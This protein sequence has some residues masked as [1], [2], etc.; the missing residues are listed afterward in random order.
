MLLVQ[1]LPSPGLTSRLDSKPVPSSVFRAE[2]DILLC[3]LVTPSR[4]AQVELVLHS[5]GPLIFPSWLCQVFP[6][7]Q[8]LPCS[9]ALALSWR[10]GTPTYVAWRLP[11]FFP[12]RGFKCIGHFV[13]QVSKSRLPLRQE[14]DG[15]RGVFPRGEC[16]SLQLP[17]SFDHPFFSER[18]QS[19]TQAICFEKFFVV[20]SPP[21][22]L[23]SITF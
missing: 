19:F 23:V 15:D 16:L 13:G 3:F 2:L 9:R 20:S 7:Y 11:P 22:C 1:Y 4:E 21:L 17:S 8:V 18:L 6:T 12:S 5:P 10:L 14:V